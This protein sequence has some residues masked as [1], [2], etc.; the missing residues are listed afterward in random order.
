MVC[1]FVYDKPWDNKSGKVAQKGHIICRGC[2]VLHRFATSA[3]E[4]GQIAADKAG[5]A[6]VG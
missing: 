1:A 5:Q 3:Q 4:T 6:Q 2:S